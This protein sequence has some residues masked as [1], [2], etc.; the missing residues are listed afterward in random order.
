MKNK[1]AFIFYCQRCAVCLFLSLFLGACVVGGGV[2]TGG[3]QRN[4]EVEKLFRSA[5]LLSDHNYYIQGT[6]SDP[7]AIIALLN[8]FHLR[9]RLWTQVDW[10]EKDL[11]DAVF[12]MRNAEIGFCVTEGG[13]LVAPGDVQVGI[14]YS[15]RELSTIKQPEP[16][17]VEV[18][19]FDYIYGSPCHKQHVLDEL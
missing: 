12:W 2:S 14:W 6:R 5:T 18:Y 16:D 1:T 3:P 11:E 13:Y 19:P 8:T 9:S 15:Q 10:T 7:E 4:L 17:I